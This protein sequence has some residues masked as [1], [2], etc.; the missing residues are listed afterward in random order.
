MRAAVA[1]RLLL[2]LGAFRGFAQPP[3]SFL[4]GT[5]G[6]GG[7]CGIDGLFS[8][9]TGAAR[10][11]VHFAG[12]ACR[13]IR[14]LR[15][16]GLGGHGLGVGSVNRPRPQDEAEQDGGETRGHGGDTHSLPPN[17]PASSTRGPLSSATQQLRAIG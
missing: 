10:R 5:R 15:C 17:V 2:L 16:G 8:L 3:G 11:A 9:A 6:L 4:T 12:T 7:W 13:L 14:R 1:P